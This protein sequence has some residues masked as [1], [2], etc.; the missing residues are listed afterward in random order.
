MQISNKHLNSIAKSIASE[1][2]PLFSQNSQSGKLQQPQSASMKSQIVVAGLV[3]V[4]G[5]CLTLV[6]LTQALNYTVCESASSSS[7]VKEVNINDCTSSIDPCPF[8]RGLNKT[9]EV[10][11]VPNQNVK[12]VKVKVAGKINKLTVPF[13]ISPDDACGRYGLTCPLEAG[14]NYT[15]KLSMPILR[16]YPKLSVDV[17]LRLKDEDKVVLCVEIPARIQELPKE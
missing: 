14:Q 6:D 12:A 13:H 1:I 4:A 3:L 2:I 10:S 5:Y 9:I 17:F 8:I 16:T 11:F 7:A 15:F